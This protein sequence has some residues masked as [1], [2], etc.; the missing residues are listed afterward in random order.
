MMAHLTFGPV[1]AVSDTRLVVCA[2]NSTPPSIVMTVASEP[3]LRKSRRLNSAPSRSCSLMPENL[4]V[5]GAKDHPFLDAGVQLC[6]Y[7]TFAP[8]QHRLTLRCR[9]RRLEF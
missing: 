6:Q 9:A 4:S 7:R 1:G 5:R 2:S 3:P 8:K